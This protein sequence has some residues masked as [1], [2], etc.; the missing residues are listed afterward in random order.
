MDAL[1]AEQDGDMEMYD[2]IYN[3]HFADQ[4][5]Y[6]FMVALISFLFRNGNLIFYIPDTN[7]MTCM[8][9]KQI[10]YKLFGIYIGTL[11]IDQYQYDLTCIPMW[12]NMIYRVNVMDYR[13]FLYYYPNDAV[14]QPDIMNKIVIEMNPYGETY[15]EKAKYVLD[16]RTKIKSNIKLVCPLFSVIR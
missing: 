12:L 13:E 8:K 5:P 4:Y 6:E 10:I 9:F 14:I 3:D 11:G 7:S 1:I 15:E 16:F 2:A